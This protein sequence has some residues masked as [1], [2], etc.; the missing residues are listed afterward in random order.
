[1]ELPLQ[2]RK[3]VAVLLPKQQ[4]PH[5]PVVPVQMDIIRPMLKRI[6]AAERRRAEPRR[7]LRTH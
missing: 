3:L 6:A 7:D 5:F 2:F 4:Y 1:M